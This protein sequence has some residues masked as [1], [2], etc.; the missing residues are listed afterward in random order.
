MDELLLLKPLML[1]LLFSLYLSL[2]IMMFICHFTL[3]LALRW[4][5]VILFSVDGFEHQPSILFDDCKIDTGEKIRANN[6]RDGR[7]WWQKM[8]A[9][10]AS[11]M[12]PAKLCTHTNTYFS[13][14]RF[15]I[16]PEARWCNTGGGL[17]VNDA[18]FLAGQ[19]R[20]ISLH[21]SLA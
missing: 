14:F 12:K 16:A 19:I 7:I 8:C 4:Y 13:F 5:V 6:P 21:Y 15:A 1:L 18:Y 17:L 11:W 3:S 9:I 10:Y 2:F 20:I